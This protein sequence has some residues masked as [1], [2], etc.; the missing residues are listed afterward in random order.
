MFWDRRVDSLG[1][2]SKNPKTCSLW[3]GCEKESFRKILSLDFV[4][5][6]ELL[7]VCDFPRSW[8]INPKC[9]THFPAGDYDMVGVRSTEGRG[10]AG[11]DDLSFWPAHFVNNFFKYFLNRKAKSLVLLNSAFVLRCET[12]SV[13]IGESVWN[14]KAEFSDMDLS[15]LFGG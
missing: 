11:D 14:A 8:H 4:L 7:I 13:G 3:D 1:D 15:G 9:I 12:T 6:G 5:E 10:R 2:R